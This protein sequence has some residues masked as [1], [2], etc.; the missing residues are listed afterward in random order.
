MIDNP[1]RLAPP[2]AVSVEVALAPVHNILS[3][4]AWL[5]APA[6]APGADPWLAQT[7]AL[8]S[9]DER[10]TNRLIFEGLGAAL[11]PV[12]DLADFSLYLESLAAADPATLAARVSP[13]TAPADLHAA[14]VALCADPPALRDRI[15]THLRRA[16]DQWLGPE[17]RRQARS[18]QGLVQWLQTQEWPAAP[19]AATIRAFIGRELPA[20]V[21]GQLDGVAHLVF[22]LALHV[23]PWAACFGTAD[24]LWVFVRGRIDELPLR[25]GPVQRPELIASLAALA[26]TTGLQILEQLA[27]R[28]EL[29][30]QEIMARLDLSQSSA[31]RHLQQ[32]LRAGFLRE[33]RVAGTNKYYWLNPPRLDWTFRALQQLLEGS[34]P[35][36]E[37]PEL[38]SDVPEALRRFVDQNGRLVAWPAKSQRLAQAAIPDYLASRFTA[39]RTYTEREVNEVLNAWHTYGDPAT[40]RRLLYDSHRLDRARDGSSYWLATNEKAVAAGS[41]PT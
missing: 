21:A 33:R 14:V 3:S 30:A 32:L 38:Q 10:A 4:M 31:S 22:V 9:A 36:V 20:Q 28:A 13:A 29:S 35:A 15:V 27:P 12:P 37:A 41:S 7:A 23:G 2:P 11:L 24:T 18:L 34:A 6:A 26:D 39:G 19:A 25:Q 1:F 8:L 40:L 17:W 5:H 16:W